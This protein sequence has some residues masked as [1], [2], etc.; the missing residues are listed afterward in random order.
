M[1]QLTTIHWV[2]I[3]LVVIVLGVMAARRDTLLPCIVGLF[4]IGYM[5]KG[6]LPGA[7]Q[8]M[9]NALVSAGSEFLGIITII[10]LVVALSKYLSEAGSDYLIM[11]PAAKLMV[12]ANVAFWLLGIGM[13]ITSWFVWP[14]PAV[15]LIGAILMPVAVRAGLPVIGAAMAMNLFGHGIGLSTDW[16]IQGAPSITAKFAGL[17]DASAVT[18]AGLPLFVVMS[19]STTVIAFV[20]LKRDMA[21]NKLEV[22]EQTLGYQEAAA[23]GEAR[24]FSPVAKLMA[25]VT[26]LAFI[27]D[28]VA[29]LKLDL[30]GGDATALIGGTALALMTI[31]ATLEFKGE[32]FEKITDYVRDGFM[33]GIKIFAPVII[34]GAF[35]FLGAEGTAKAILGENATGLMSDFA[36]WMAQNVPLSRVP[37][38][39]IQLLVG[40]VQGL[41]GSGFA[42]LPLVGTMA[43]TFGTAI[44]ANIGVLAALGQ[45]GGVWVGG[46]TII[47]WGIIPVAAICGV[48]PMDLARRNFLPVMIGFLLTV[49]TA[50]IIM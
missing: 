12:N 18:M 20:L 46:G 38:A 2:Y 44:D 36:T 7:L 26:P 21:K 24:T 10:S 25:V 43:K 50:I 34:I 5:A 45:I 13:M 6:T 28:I 40:G 42:P 49:I 15:A 31:G 32:A 14:S 30:K 9:Y 47:P 22:S 29:M 35:F 1:V 8:V 4:I 3:A 48:E 19:V 17:P 41:D 39:F 16:I 33:F 27:L 11:R 23:T 37:V